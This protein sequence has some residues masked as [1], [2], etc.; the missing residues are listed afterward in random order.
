MGTLDNS[1]KKLDSLKDHLNL[2]KMIS[3]LL[4]YPTNGFQKKMLRWN[5]I[6]R[7]NW[8]VEKSTLKNSS[9]KMIEKSWNSTLDIKELHSSYITS[10]LM[11]LSKLEK[12]LFLTLAKIPSLSPSKDKNF[13]D[14]L[15]LINLVKHMLKTS[16]KQKKFQLEAVLRSLAEHTISK[17]VTNSPE[18]IMKQSLEW[19]V[20][21]IKVTQQLVRSH[22]QVILNLLRHHHSS[23]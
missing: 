19:G 22:D 16:S 8:A 21:I 20:L 4:P 6:L 13:R 17:V 23:S 5:S 9:L 10:L 3:G 12:L 11:T 14:S 2:M 7:R 15:L 18:I 1:M